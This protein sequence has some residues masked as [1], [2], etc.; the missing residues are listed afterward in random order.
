MMPRLLKNTPDHLMTFEQQL[1]FF[2]DYTLQEDIGE[3]DHST[4]AC[5]PPDAVGISKLLV[6]EPCVLAG[7]EIVEPVFKKIDPDAVIQFYKTDGDTCQVG[8]IAFEVKA[9]I[10]ALLSAERLMLNILQRMSGIATRTR[11]LVGMISHTRCRLLDTRKTTPGMRFLEK[12]A[13]SIGGGYNHRF[14]LYDMIMLKDNHIDFAGGIEKAIRKTREYLAEKRLSLKIEVECRNLN[15][16]EQVLKAGGVH[17]IM[18]DNFSPPLIVEALKLVNNTLETE[19]SGGITEK[20]IVEYAETGVDF[21]S[22]GALTHSVKSV[23]LSFK[24]G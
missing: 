4:L 24:A 15:E 18:F 5:I 19:A 23:D 7:A 22:L 11:R 10:H 17:R 3:G 21:I 8:D 1:D 13:V 20:N 6:K 16:V 12:R 9:R 14:G 2:I